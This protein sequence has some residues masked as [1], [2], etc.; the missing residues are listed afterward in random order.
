MSYQGYGR[1]NRDTNDKLQSISSSYQPWCIGHSRNGR[2]VKG[3]GNPTPENSWSSIIDIPLEQLFSWVG[4]PW[5]QTASI[6]SKWQII[7]P[8]V[9]RDHFFWRSLRNSPREYMLS[10]SE[11]LFLKDFSDKRNGISF[12]NHWPWVWIL[13]LPF[14]STLHFHFQG[15]SREGNGSSVREEK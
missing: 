5:R 12:S 11:W 6:N 2:R 13:F 1:G 10:A 9:T 3:L 4:D 7:L 15:T 14:P 8:V